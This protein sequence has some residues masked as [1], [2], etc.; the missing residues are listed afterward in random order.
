LLKR[1]NFK[2]TIVIPTLNSQKYLKK[3]LSTLKQQIFQNFIIYV[4]DGGSRDGTLELFKKSKLKYEIISKKDKSPEEA[5]NKCFKKIKTEYFTILG[6]DDFYGNKFYL[7]NLVNSIKNNNIDFV[8]P[9]LAFIYGNKIVHKSSDYNFN[10]IRYRPIFPGYGWLAT[11][12]ISKIL[13]DERYKVASDY[14]FLLKVYQK[15][16]KFYRQNNSIYCFRAGGF[17][18]RS[19]LKGLK[20]AKE[21]SIKFK[22]P[23]ILIYTIYY[24]QIIKYI[25]K[26]FLQ[27]LLKFN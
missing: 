23:K 20:E 13:F 18:S 1:L 17:S 10:V 19:Y 15:K 16:Y 6:S 27:N 26:I 5:V 25:L 9:G 7:Q 22:G 24:F 3:T 21:I 14:D 4:A 12:K 8:M 11:Q 2:L